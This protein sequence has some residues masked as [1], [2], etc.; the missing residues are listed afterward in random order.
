MAQ[1]QSSFAQKDPIMVRNAR[2]QS[3]GHKLWMEIL[4]ALVVFLIGGMVQNTISMIPTMIGLFQT[5][6]YQKM[7]E[8][9]QNGIFDLQA[10]IPQIMQELPEWL[11]IVTLFC[12]AGTIL[13]VLFYCTK[14]E[15]RKLSTLGL[16]KKH[17]V[18]EYIIGLGVGLL[19]FVLVYGLNLLVGGAV[20]QGFAFRPQML[21]IL[22]VSLLGYVVQGASEEIFC[23][24]YFCNSV[25]RWMPLW[26]GLVINSLFFAFMHGS[27]PGVS[28]L[29]LLNLFL[30]GVFM[31]IYMIRRGNL[32]GAC[33]IH[34]IWNFVQGNIFGMQVSG[35][36]SNTSIFQ[37][38][39]TDKMS[40][41]NGGAFGPEGGL[42]VTIVLIAA[43]LLVWLFCKNRDLGQIADPI[44][45]PTLQAVQK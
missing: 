5:P 19:M 12:T 27:N 29:A 3:Q 26:V 6:T 24:G 44:P 42:C 4:I 38:E 45:Q 34:S 11:I 22:I 17:A 7:L 35:M 43:I 23:R 10:F 14:I 31:T 13:T 9:M 16:T 30:F 25:A 2:L 28:P 1:K 39:Q 21:P 15:K 36:V 37:T 33:A 40:I 41:W 18:S 20:F 32:W 8:S